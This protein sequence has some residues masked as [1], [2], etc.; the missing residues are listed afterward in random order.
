MG[1]LLF[2]IQVLPLRAGVNLINPSQPHKAAEM[3][4]LHPGISRSSPPQLRASFVL[5]QFEI[6]AYRSLSSSDM[7][8]SAK[9]PF[10]LLLNHRTSSSTSF[11]NASIFSFSTLTLASSFFSSA[12]ETSTVSGKD[13]ISSSTANPLFCLFDLFPVADIPCWSLFPMRVISIS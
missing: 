12:D 2:P 8:F 5:E 3:F 1:Q 7:L 10:N 13:S 6:R 9:Q 11:L 4:I